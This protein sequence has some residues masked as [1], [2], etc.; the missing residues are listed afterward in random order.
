MEVKLLT[1]TSYRR[2]AKALAERDAGLAQILAN[3]GL[4]PFIVRPSGFAGLIH[5]IV[6]QQVSTEA[7]QAI[8]A[9]LTEA[10]GGEITAQGCLKLGAE[11]LREAG[12]SRPKVRSV[13]EIAAAVE[14]GELDLEALQRLPD[15]AAAARLLQLRG[16]GTWTAHSFLLFTLRRADVWPSGDLALEVAV[17]QLHGHVVKLGSVEVDAIAVVWRPYRAVAARILWHEYRCQRG[18]PAARPT[19]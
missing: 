15:E 9:K 12:L 8:Y 3:R 11:G 5:T 13:T 1:P 17:S 4:P 10:L 2:A 14:A 7:A 19:P 18:R 6:A 16:V